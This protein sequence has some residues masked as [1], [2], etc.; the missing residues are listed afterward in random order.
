MSSAGQPNRI[1]KLISALQGLGKIYIQQG[2]LEKAL[3]SYA[4]LV[5]VHPTESQAWLRLGILRINANQPSEAIDDFKKVI[6]IDPKS[7]VPVTIW[8]GYT[9][10]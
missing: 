6:E 7:A 4:K 8:P 5:K 2:N 3:D 10:I 9:P 1:F